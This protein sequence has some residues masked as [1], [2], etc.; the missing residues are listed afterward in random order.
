[1][2][3]INSGKAKTIS[4]NQT[5]LQ[6]DRIKA[7]HDETIRAINQQHDLQKVRITTS[8]QQALMQQYARTGQYPHSGLRWGDRS[9]GI[10]YTGWSNY[11]QAYQQLPPQQRGTVLEI[12]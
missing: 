3:V 10:E 9:S 12:N 2:H 6:P 11:H 1:M 8:A 7:Q 5:K 4:N